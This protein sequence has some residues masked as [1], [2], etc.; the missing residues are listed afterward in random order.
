[1]RAHMLFALSLSTGLRVAEVVALDC[2]DVLNRR[3]Q[4]RTRIT[5]RTFKGV[6]A[7]DKPQSVMVPGSLRAK[8]SRLAV[9][10]TRR[11]ESVSTE[12]P[13]FVGRQGRLSK[14]RAQQLF[15]TFAERAELA[16][17]LTFHALRHTFCQRLFERTRDVRL[18]QHAARHKQIQTTTIYTAPSDD[19][20]L[21]ALERIDL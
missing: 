11:G 3:Q 14:R 6:R 19:E 17:G 9:W 13:L 15:T 16:P 21:A 5:L 8:L 18:V 12:A 4:G 20:V 1:M 10:K 2:G 7:G